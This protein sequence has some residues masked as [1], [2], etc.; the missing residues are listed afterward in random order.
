MHLEP[1]ME[2]KHLDKSLIT[3]KMTIIEFRICFFSDRHWS[4][5]AARGRQPRAP[6]TQPTQ[7]RESVDA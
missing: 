6:P 2:E 1:V 7:I 3:V 5:E 4:S